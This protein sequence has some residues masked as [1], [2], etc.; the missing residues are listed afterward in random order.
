M[1][2]SQWKF[3]L[4]I[5]GRGEGE[6]QLKE[7]I[8]AQRKENIQFLRCFP[9]NSKLQ[10][11]FWSVLEEWRVMLSLI[12]I[13][14]IWLENLSILMRILYSWDIPPS[15]F[16]L[17]S[18]SYLLDVIYLLQNQPYIKKASNSALKV[19]FQ[20]PRLPETTYLV[21]TV[22][23]VALDNYC[24]EKYISLPARI[25]RNTT[26]SWMQPVA[27]LPAIQETIGY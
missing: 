25:R 23:R 1:H 21:L 9:N 26:I 13:F 3:S 10:S 19:Y 24:E 14:E 4:T 2:N 12:N 27:F 5:L 16:K 20:M 17:D 11:M 8:T 7:N 22:S 15:T 18:W 6:E